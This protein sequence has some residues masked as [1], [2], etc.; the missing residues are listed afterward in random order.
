MAPEVIRSQGQGYSAKVDIWSLGCVVLEMFAGKRPWSREEAIGA[1]YKLGSLNQA[2][3]IPEDVSRAISIEGLSFMYDC[4]TIDP[5]ERP[6]AETLLRA[7]FCF[8]DPNYNFL[9]TELYAKIRG[10]FQ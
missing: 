6:T 9:D 7:P 3:P 8:S 2:P 4:F 1:I 5:T 10:A